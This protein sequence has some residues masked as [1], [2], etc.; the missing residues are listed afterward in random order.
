MSVNEIDGL[1]LDANLFL[2]DAEINHMVENSREPPWESMPPEEEEIG[3]YYTDVDVYHMVENSRE[4]PWEKMPPEE[5]LD[6]DVMEEPTSV[7]SEKPKKKTKRSRKDAEPSENY[8]LDESEDELPTE[9]D[10]LFLNDSETVHQ[11]VVSEKLDRALDPKNILDLPT[12]DEQGN[13]RSFRKRKVPEFFG[14]EEEEEYYKKM[15]EDHAEDC[16]KYNEPLCSDDEPE[17]APVVD[18]IDDDDETYAPAPEE[19]DEDEDDDDSSDDETDQ[20]SAAFILFGKNDGEYFFRAIDAE[21]MLLESSEDCI[22]LE[23]M[24][25]SVN[26]VTDKDTRFVGTSQEIFLEFLKTF[27]TDVAPETS[28]YLLPESL[29]DEFWWE[30]I[31]D[32]FFSLYG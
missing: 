29:E 32:V 30:G 10:Q 21:G 9:E 22:N 23:E 18:D 28:E 4:P 20:A 8:L 31:G 16:A 7:D 17:E 12:H 2:T 5:D 19:L 24:I 26:N 27:Y 6:L 25:D 13:R 14:M 3:E 15:A 1:D 11:D